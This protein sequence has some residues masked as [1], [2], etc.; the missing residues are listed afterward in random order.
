MPKPAHGFT[1]IELLVVITIIAILSTVGMTVYSGIQ[2]RTRDTKRIADVNAIAKA[3]TIY[4]YATGSPPPTSGVADSSVESG[5]T[6]WPTGAGTF[7]NAVDPL[8]IAQ[9]PLD[10][11]NG[12]VACSGA[13]CGYYYTAN[14]WC[15]GGFSGSRCDANVPAVY[16]YLE[17]CTDSGD[18]GMFGFSCSEGFYLRVGQSPSLS[19]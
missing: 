4:A 7:K 18:A 9:L 2:K 11:S 16:T 12:Q 8:Y 19:Q 1:L 3:A 15:K 14:M 6:N 5:G 17:N 13:T 10:P